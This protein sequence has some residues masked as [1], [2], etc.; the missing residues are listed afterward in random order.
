M[1][2]NKIEDALAE[3]ILARKVKNG[4]YVEV[5]LKKKEIVFEVKEKTSSHKE[6]NEI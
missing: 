1:I 6:Q 2:Q 3:E 4:D 5:G